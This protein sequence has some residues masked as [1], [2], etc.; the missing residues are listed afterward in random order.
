MGLGAGFLKHVER[1]ACLW[2]VLDYSLGEL[3]VQLRALRRELN[4]FRDGLGDRPAAI[5]VNK[6][7][8]AKDENE[9]ISRGP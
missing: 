5:V 1:C 8:L 7:D 9:V 3:D 2:F 6:V 4:A